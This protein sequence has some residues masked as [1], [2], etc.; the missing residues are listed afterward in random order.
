AADARR[1]LEPAHELGVDAVAVR[2]APAHRA[3][4]VAELC[5]RRVVCGRPLGELAGD[6]AVEQP[7]RL[8]LRVIARVVD[9]L[10]DAHSSA[11]PDGAGGR[12]E[13]L[14]DRRAALDAHGGEAVHLLAATRQEHQARER[15]GRDG[16]RGGIAH[17]GAGTSSPRSAIP[18]SISAIVVSIT[19]TR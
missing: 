6:L 19:F 1:L 9:A 2:R 18:D 3:Y 15:E 16:R 4:E 14:Q 5:G 10:G 8:E 12:L 13:R 17:A 7:E 11:Q